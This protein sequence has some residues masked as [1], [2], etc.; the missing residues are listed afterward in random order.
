MRE[1]YQS[2]E[3][4]LRV[5]P[6]M[7]M[8]DL[9]RM[10]AIGPIARLGTHCRGEVNRRLGLRQDEK[11]VL[12]SMGGIATRS[13]IASW[14]VMPGV[15]WLV[16]A[17]WQA[18]RPDVAVLESLGMDFIDVLRSCDAFV[19]KPGYG[20]FA[21]AACNGVPL[22][23]VSRHDWPEE[24][25]LVEWLSQHGRCAEIS[26]QAFEAGD[27]QAALEDVWGQAGA[28]PVLPSGIVDAADYLLRSINMASP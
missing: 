26:R 9:D 12:V 13:P 8:P 18:P 3:T 27:L 11:L 28:Q 6:G 2:A 1:A 16:P 19:C 7:E 4:F 21:E 17:D 22:L 10:R 14:P 5:T 24:P 23:Y 25:C 15:R 20:S